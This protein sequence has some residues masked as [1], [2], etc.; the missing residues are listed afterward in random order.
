MFQQD[1]IS[2][3]DSQDDAH[4]RNKNKI[5]HMSQIQNFKIRNEISNYLKNN[6][7]AAQKVTSSFYTKK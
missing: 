5:C 1:T 6:L 4:I 7:L 3:C 2:S